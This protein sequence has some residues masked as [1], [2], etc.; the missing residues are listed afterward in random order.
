[1]RPIV[2]LG[3]V[4]C[5]LTTLP[6]TDSPVSLSRPYRV[7][8]VQFLISSSPTGQTVEANA[9]VPYFLKSRVQ[10]VSFPHRNVTSLISASPS[11]AQ[12]KTCYSTSP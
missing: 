9:T 6:I 10:R 4:V 5:R 7:P 8:R 12:K 2:Q 1:M 3:H 11:S